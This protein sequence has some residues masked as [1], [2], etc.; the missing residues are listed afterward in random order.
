MNTVGVNTGIPKGE[1]VVF[2]AK[3]DVGKS[4]FSMSSRPTCVVCGEHITIGG[5][6]CP[7]REP[8]F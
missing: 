1:L 6:K 7:N 2:L 4:V 8:T 3:S 5:C